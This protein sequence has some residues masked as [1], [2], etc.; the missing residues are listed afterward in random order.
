MQI[1]KIKCFALVSILHRDT[2]RFF[3]LSNPDFLCLFEELHKSIFWE[4]IQ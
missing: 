2:T 4:G 3:T 1:K